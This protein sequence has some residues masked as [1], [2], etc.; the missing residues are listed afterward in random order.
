MDD[1]LHLGFDRLGQL[2]MVPE[3]REEDPGVFVDGLEKLVEVGG[4]V[5]SIV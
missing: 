2:E 4:P 3:E 1:D 5:A